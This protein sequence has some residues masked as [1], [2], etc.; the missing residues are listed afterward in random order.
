VQ[1]Q[2]HVE[3]EASLEVEHQVKWRLKAQL[4]AQS[5]GALEQACA[6]VQAAEARTQGPGGQVGT[7]GSHQRKGRNDMVC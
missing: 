3:Q 7:E 1:D 6:T 5:N 2:E 4:L